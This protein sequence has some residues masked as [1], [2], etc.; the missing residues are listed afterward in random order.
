MCLLAV[1]VMGRKIT[2]ATKIK[3]RDELTLLDLDNIEV[4]LQ[5]LSK[6]ENNGRNIAILPKDYK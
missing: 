4:A 1:F 6:I 3:T 5:F 2:R